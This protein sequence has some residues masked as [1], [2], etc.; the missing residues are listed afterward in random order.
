MSVRQVEA[1]TATPECYWLC[2]VVIEDGEVTSEALRTKA[3]FVCD[4]GN[5][6][7]DAWSKY[8]NLANATPET[9]GGDDEASLEVSGQEVKFRIGHKV[10]SGGLCFD[11]AM[12]K[13]KTG[14]MMIGSI[15]DT[16]DS[17]QSCDSDVV[18]EGETP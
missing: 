3:R 5:T 15:A 4:I 16:D 8:K 17:E 18:L 1:A 14:V 2:V 13:L 9:V 12:V 6:L 7:K 11:E 10:W